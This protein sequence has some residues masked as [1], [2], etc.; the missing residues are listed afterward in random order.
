[1]RLK[2]RSATIALV[3]GAMLVPT[4]ASAIPGGEEGGGEETGSGYSVEVRLSG[5]GAPGGGGD[6]YTIHVPPV[7]WWEPIAVM[8][9]V[10]IT[11]PEEIREYFEE[12]IRPWLRG[13]AAAGYFAWP[14]YEVFEDA[15]RR[16]GAG[17]EI[18]FYQIEGADKEAKMACS[19]QINHYDGEDI[20][21]AYWPFATGEQPDP[22]VD[23]EDLAEAARDEMVIEAPE[24]DRN[25]QGAG[26]L[27]GATLVGFDTWFWV[28]N[29]EESIG[30]A[31]GERRIR[32]EVVGGTVWAE[33]TAQTDGLTV[34][35][36]AGRADC[37]PALAIKAWSPGSS[38]AEGCTVSFTRA[39]VQYPDGYPVSA[40]V[41]WAA[42][43][44]GVTQ[45][46]EQVGG[47]LAGR[48]ES[49]VVNVPVAESQATVR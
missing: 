34:A 26:A 33:V 5:D 15:I 10:D 25:P 47:D 1:M 6:G 16:A 49:V 21:V 46:G 39:S 7:C 32:A 8:P 41:E 24:I 2:H 18:T 3:A 9:G 20:P 43:W 44:E 14:S 35:S 31:D 12:E 30:G 45:D 42:T 11:D 37:E 22:V 23:P 13:H 4:T 19:P 36:P 48:S 38:D 17:E 29:P 40:S 28:T 27:G